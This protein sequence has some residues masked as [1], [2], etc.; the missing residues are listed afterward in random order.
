MATLKET[1]SSYR[2]W[3]QGLDKYIKRIEA[4]QEIEDRRIALA[5]LLGYLESAKFILTI[6][7]PEN[8]Q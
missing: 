6:D 3:I 4:A 8:E 1:I 5:S 7:Y 2:H